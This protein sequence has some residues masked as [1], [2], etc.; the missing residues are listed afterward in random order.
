[1]NMATAVCLPDPVLFRHNQTAD[2]I[3]PQ[4]KFLISEMMTT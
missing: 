3:L 1:M 4:I 2:N